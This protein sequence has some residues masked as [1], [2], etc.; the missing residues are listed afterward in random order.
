[1]SGIIPLITVKQFNL[2]FEKAIKPLEFVEAI[3]TQVPSLPIS[4][5]KFREAFLIFLA[6]TSYETNR[7]TTLEEPLDYSW[8]EL[9]KR[10]SYRFAPADAM[11]YEHNPERIAN[12]I[13]AGNFGNGDEASGDGWRYRGRGVIKI[14]G[15][16]NYQEFANF[17]NLT[18]DEALQYIVTPAGAIAASVWY[19]RSKNLMR[20]IAPN[21]MITVTQIITGSSASNDARVAELRRIIGR[22]EAYRL[23][24]EK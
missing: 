11:D 5:I 12:R 4:T 3:N 1:M 20:F 21:H 14:V 22:L 17:S 18:L 16:D 10:W 9:V 6:Q 19:W 15:K 23:A 2:L 13:H 8:Q 24:T 7:Y